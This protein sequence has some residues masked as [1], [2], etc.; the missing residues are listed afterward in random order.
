MK[1]H[2]V[3]TQFTQGFI[4]PLEPTFMLQRL[5]PSPESKDTC[6]PTAPPPGPC[7]YGCPLIG[8]CRKTRVCCRAFRGYVTNGVKNFEDWNA[9]LGQ[10]PQ[11]IDKEETYHAA[12]QA[13]VV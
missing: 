12:H 11:S 8:L 7:D 3:K 5:L 6:L 10:Y 9:Y 13:R 1:T 2:F 4:G